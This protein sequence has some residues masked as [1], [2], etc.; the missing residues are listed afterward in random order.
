LT[1]YFSEVLSLRNTAL[2]MQ[3][4]VQPLFNGPIDLVGD[5][6][7][8]IGALTELLAHLGYDGGGLHREK[9]RLVFLG[10]LT[11]RGPDSPAVVRLVQSLVEAG[12]AECVLGNHDLNILLG[13]HKHDNPWFY[14]K[15]F[16]AHD[17]SLVP[18]VLADDATRKTVT[19]FFRT[20]PLALEREGLRV[21]HAY[22]DQGMIEVARAATCTVTLYERYREIIGD[23][24]SLRPG[25][26][27]IY[28]KLEHQNR[29]PVKLLTSGP[30]ERIDPPIEVSGK[31]R[32]EGRVAWWEAY[33]DS[34][35]CVFGHYS[36]PSSV[37]RKG[38]AICVDFG[39]GK[40]S[41]ERLNHNWVAKTK[42]AALRVPEM[43]IVFDDG[44]TE[45]LSVG[46]E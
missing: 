28:R 9:R 23:S 16:H 45:L 8:E 37:R 14:G 13:L 30:E 42:L 2:P 34:H 44:Q 7:G 35:F 39:V 27:E 31:V 40:R 38:R 26:D 36:L 22:W 33:S 20:L 3:S 46:S 24:H 17:G 11:D 4:L 19:N 21:V 5:V 29:N 41:M 1:E 6:H 18:Q 10:D 25:M 32:H 15:E 12:R 43:Q